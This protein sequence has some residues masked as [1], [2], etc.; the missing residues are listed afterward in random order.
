MVNPVNQYSAWHNLTWKEKMDI[1]QQGVSQEDS[2]LSTYV[3]IYIALEAMFFAIVLTLGLS[4]WLTLI[5]GLLALGVSFLFVRI[6]LRRGD[7]VDRWEEIMCNLWEQAANAAELPLEKNTCIEFVNHYKGSR[8]RRNRGKWSN[9]WGW[10]WWIKISEND[11]KE[12]G[13]FEWF[14]Q[15]SKRKVMLGPFVSARWI[16]V[17]LMP[18]MVG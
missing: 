16:L 9:F 8:E 3:T 4:W 11:E 12:Q 18:L 14:S 15:I 10:R 17:T 2:L 13:K 5:I 1:C 7:A 6:F